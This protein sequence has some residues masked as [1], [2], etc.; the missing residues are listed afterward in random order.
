MNTKIVTALIIIAS[1]TGLGDSVHAQSPV[2]PEL[3]TGKY[4]LNGR[5]L[6]GISRRTAGN[7][8]ARFFSTKNPVNISQQ[9]T[10]ANISGKNATDN[11]PPFLQSVPIDNQ[12]D[13]LVLRRPIQ[14]PLSSPNSVIFP[15]PDRSFDANDGVQVQVQHQ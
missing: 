13:Q 5:S 12:D 3:G 4:T 6:T 11:I 7:D 15:Q 14:Q 9:N 8:F 10:S 2:T 1:L